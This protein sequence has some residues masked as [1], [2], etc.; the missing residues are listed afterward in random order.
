MNSV[1]PEKIH[2]RLGQRDDAGGRGHH[3]CA[4]GRGNIQAPVGIAWLAVENS[5]TA[6]DAGYPA[7]CRPDP[8]VGPVSACIPALARL[9]GEDGVLANALIGFWRRCDMGRFESVDALDY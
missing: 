5:L 9:A 7:A 4:G 1:P 8:A 6:V 3:R 2:V